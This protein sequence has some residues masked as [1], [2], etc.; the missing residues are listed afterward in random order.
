MRASPSCTTCGLSAG[1]C[2]AIPSSTS[3]NACP[4]SSV[5]CRPAAKS[6]ASVGLPMASAPQRNQTVPPPSR[7]RP[8][9]QVRGPGPHRRPGAADRHLHGRAIISL[10]AGPRSTRQLGGHPG[11]TAHGPRRDDPR[12]RFP[13][14]TAPV[15][16]EISST[17][18][19]SVSAL[20]RTLYRSQ[21]K[22][23]SSATGVVHQ[24]GDATIVSTNISWPLAPH[25]WRSATGTQTTTA[26][27]TP[28]S[29]TRRQP[30]T[31]QLPHQFHVL[32]IDGEV[33][34]CGRP[35]GR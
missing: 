12:D 14:R 5:S 18:A 11:R 10:A 30:S 29:A 19:A 8:H 16:S 7:R 9:A 33:A 21:I 1:T 28:R 3:W 15:D 23:S 24:S 17:I 4:T 20:A 13:I 2:A 6:S 32:Q 27:D 22:N 35:L 25:G 34:Y 26:G 31:L